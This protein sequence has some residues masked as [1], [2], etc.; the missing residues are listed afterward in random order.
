MTLKSKK[1]RAFT[2]LEVTITMAI[3]AILIALVYS[4]VNFLTKQN[5][6]ELNTKTEINQWLIMRKQ[7]LYDVYTSYSLEEIENGFEL[8]NENNTI[9]YYEED[10]QLYILKNTNLIRTEYNNVTIDWMG[11]ETDENRHCELIVPVSEE[12]MKLHF[13]TFSDNSNRINK[14]FK[15]EMLNGGNE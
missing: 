11:D 6:D 15:S 10:G 13:L 5:F 4:A 12:P 8:K 14:W 3:S 2:I 1:I 7:I 9:R